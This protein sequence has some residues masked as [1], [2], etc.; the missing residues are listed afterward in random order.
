MKHNQKISDARK[1]LGI[2]KSATEQEVRRAYRDLVKKWHPDTNKTKEAKNKMQ[3]INHAFE[4]IMKEQ[5]N[6]IDPWEDYGK[7]WLK[8][9][10]NDPIWGNYVSEEDKISIPHKKKS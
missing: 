5:F 2:P 4:I 9:Y 7:W 3:E 6:V 8:Q 10:G 1:I